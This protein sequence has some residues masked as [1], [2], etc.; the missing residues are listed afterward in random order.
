MNEIEII[1]KISFKHKKVAREGQ[2]D[3]RRKWLHDE[4]ANLC[5]D[6]RLVDV[7]AFT[8]SF[9]ECGHRVPLCARRTRV[10]AFAISNTESTKRHQ[11]PMASGN[12]CEQRAITRYMMDFIDY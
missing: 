7:S 8:R 5:V 4:C 11:L 9:H 10:Y 1:I 3:N 6:E 2:I 12:N